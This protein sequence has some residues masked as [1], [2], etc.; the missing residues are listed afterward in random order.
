MVWLNLAAVLSP[1]Q[2]VKALTHGAIDL[3]ERVFLHCLELANS[4]DAVTFQFGSKGFADPPDCADGSVSQE[5]QCLRFAYYRKAP[6]FF[7]IRR[8]L[9]Q[10]FAIRKPDR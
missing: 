7:H 5:G 1:R 4:S 6:G 2:A 8:D 3:H 10:K 9:G